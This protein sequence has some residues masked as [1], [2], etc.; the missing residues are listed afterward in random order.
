VTSSILLEAPKELV[1][2]VISTVIRTNLPVLTNLWLGFCPHYLAL[3]GLT[4]LLQWLMM[5]FRFGV[6]F[7]NLLSFLRLLF[8]FLIVSRAEIP[9]YRRLG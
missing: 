8:N 5:L 1:I 3:N 6:F 2:E 7:L 4:L 9:L